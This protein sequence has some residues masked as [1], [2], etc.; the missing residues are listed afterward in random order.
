VG[1]QST[2]AR[3]ATE[4]RQLRG[5]GRTRKQKASKKTLN[6]VTVGGGGGGATGKV[7]GSS[8]LEKKLDS[9]GAEPHVGQAEREAPC[10]G[11]T[12]GD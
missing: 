10:R 8:E 2:W 7:E 9:V 4:K 6:E 11:Y 1:G 12:D 5:L 3:L